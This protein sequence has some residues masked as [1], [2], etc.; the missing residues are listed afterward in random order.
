MPELEELVKS[1]FFLIALW[2][3]AKIIYL[4]NFYD[5]FLKCMIEPKNKSSDSIFNDK[6]YLDY[7]EFYFVKMFSAGS[8]Q[9]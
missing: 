7:S 5:F 3:L 9:G 2:Q 8:F 6:F 1:N 4:N